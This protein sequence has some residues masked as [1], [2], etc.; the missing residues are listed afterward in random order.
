MEGLGVNRTGTVTEYKRG[1][2]YLTITAFED[3]HCE[4]EV[5]KCVPKLIYHSCD[6]KDKEHAIESFNSL[7][8]QEEKENINKIQKICKSLNLNKKEISHV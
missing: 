8:A 6:Y 1:H 5:H 3:G 2:F 4:I 7:V